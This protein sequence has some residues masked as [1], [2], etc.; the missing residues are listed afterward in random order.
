MVPYELYDLAL[1]FKK[2]KLWQKLMDSQ[3]FAVRHSDGTTGYCCV[4]GML[5]EHCALAVY[6]GEAGLNSCRKMFIDDPDLD[7][8]DKHELNFSQDCVMVSYQLKGALNKREVAEVNAY[9]AERALKLRGKNAYPQFER[10]RPNCYPWRLSDAADQLH[11]REALEAALDVAAKL[12]SATPE[13]L[14]FT[15]GTLFERAIPLLEREGDAFRWSALELPAPWQETYV[16]PFIGDELS[17]ARIGKSKKRSG[18]WDCSIFLHIKPAS[19]EVEQGADID[20]LEEAPYF[21]YLLMIVDDG[22]GMVLDMEIFRSFDDLDALCQAVV[23]FVLDAG[24]PTQILV[25][26]DRTQAF[27]RNF[28]S[29]LG[30]KLVRR[31]E[32]PALDEA[33]QGLAEHFASSDGVAPARDVEATLELLS[34]PAIYSDLPDE[35]LTML[36]RGVQAGA[37]PEDIAR[38]VERECS[39]RG[40]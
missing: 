31:R 32:L 3:L 40:L 16:S 18:S 27:F 11:L 33:K 9:M 20:E 4:M 15:E 38:M 26:D 8:F 35:V 22:S 1:A 2:V 10:F 29:Q 13:Q 39:R 34:D 6:P 14:G 21:P 37:L 36:R 12:Q 30:V 28:A 19:D 23:R 25:V 7:V 17:L 24:R 5:G